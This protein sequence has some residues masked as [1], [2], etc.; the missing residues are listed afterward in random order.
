MDKKLVEFLAEKRRVYA[1]SP[2]NILGW[3][4]VNMTHSAEGGLGGDSKAAQQKTATRSRSAH[5]G[6]TSR[7]LLTTR[8]RC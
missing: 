5:G 7:R 4:G 2:D 1:S 6:R 3:A 8:C